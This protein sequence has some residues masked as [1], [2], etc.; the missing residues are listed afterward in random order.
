MTDSKIKLSEFL[1]KT[2]LAG[3]GLISITEERA[4]VWVDELVKR[5]EMSRKE[6]EGFV[7]SLLS[8]AEAGTKNIEEKVRNVIEKCLKKT[9]IP[10]KEDIVRLEG[11]IIELRK[12]VD[13][14]RKE[15]LEREKNI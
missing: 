10:L 13:E 15:H 1:E 9:N 4:K 8:G 5:G 11:E 14:L 3:Q 6:A 2:I 7:N 12:K